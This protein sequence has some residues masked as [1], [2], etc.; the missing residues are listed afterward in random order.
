[1][2]EILIGFPQADLGGNFAEVSLLLIRAKL[3]EGLVCRG[4]R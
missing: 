1:M 4:Q 3:L 2:R